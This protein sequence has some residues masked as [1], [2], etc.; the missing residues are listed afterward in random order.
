[1]QTEIFQDHG[2]PE[3]AFHKDKTP[4][5]HRHAR[6]RSTAR[7]AHSHTICPAHLVEEDVPDKHAHGDRLA[8]ARRAG[9]KLLSSEKQ[10]ESEEAQGHEIVT[11]HS[12]LRW[13]ALAV[14]R[15]ASPP[16]TTNCAALATD[17]VVVE[18]GREP[19]PDGPWIACVAKVEEAHLS[20]GQ[21]GSD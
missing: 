9:R 3:T 1:M 11:R 10:K 2:N 19:L 13:T 15:T 4:H 21:R 5:R 16:T 20:R 6:R 18:V 8:K 14:E 7:R 17:L 12:S